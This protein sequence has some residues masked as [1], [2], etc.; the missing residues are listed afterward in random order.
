M[1]VI[2]PC[3]GQST[4]FPNMRPKYLLCDYLGRSMIQLAAEQYLADHSVHIVILQEHEDKYNVTAQLR[5][6]FGTLANVIILPDITLGPADTVYQA[7]D[8]IIFTSD[9]NFIVKD[10]DNIFTHKRLY[11][12][13]KVFVDTLENQPTLRMPGNKSYVACNNWGIINNIV[14]KRIISD[15][16]CVGGYQ[17][18]S[19]NAYR[20]AYEAVKQ[21]KLGEIYLSSIVDYM[22]SRDAVFTTL[23]VKSYIDLGTAEDWEIHNNKPSL[24][25]DI[26][27]TIVGNQSMYGSNN[28]NEPP[29][30]LEN[31]VKALL[32]ARDKGCQ[33]I[34]TTSRSQKL[35]DVT[36]KLLDRLG[37]NMSQLI[38]GLHHS[39]RI[40]VNDFAPTNPY[41]S[42]V[43][44]NLP[45]NSDTLANYLHQFK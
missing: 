36:R 31:N 44:I 38:M 11:P 10:C 6:M 4:R 22:I 15:T 45:R 17:F 28:Y 24:L 34:F 5:S 41:P 18:N 7:L 29:T 43:A 42:A 1:D 33:I 8:A 3:A 2:I 35:H 16:F 25:I 37:F 32:D 12:G 39:R 14:E 9:Q 26:D 19:I 21:S 27:G 13:N 40:L 20:S 23:Q 30:I